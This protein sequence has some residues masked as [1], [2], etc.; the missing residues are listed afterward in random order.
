MPILRM[1]APDDSVFIEFIPKGPSRELRSPSVSP[2][3]D[4]F[5]LQSILCSYAK[6]SIFN[7]DRALLHKS[8]E[9]G[10][11]RTADGFV[12]ERLFMQC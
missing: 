1:R 2:I 5:M 11:P 8:P 4:D 7:T 12:Q 10:P 9:V 6:P 3:T